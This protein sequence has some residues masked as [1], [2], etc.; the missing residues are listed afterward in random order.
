VVIRFFDSSGLYLTDVTQRKIE[1]LVNREDYRRVLASEIGDI[2]YP[3]R[4]LDH[5]SVALQD[6]IDLDVLQASTPKLVVDYSFGSTSFAMP[7][8]WSKIGA[9]VLGVNPY[10]STWGMVNSDAATRLH[11]VADLVT[12][13]GA[14]LGASIDPD[15]E[16]LTIIDGTGHVLSDTEALLAFVELV[17]GHMDGSSIAV[18]VSVTRHV[19]DTAATGGATVHWTQTSTGALMDAALEPDVGFVG[20]AHGG[21]MLPGFLPAFDAAAALVKLLELLA[22]ADT[23]LAT[24][25]GRLPRPHVVH[26]TIVTPWDR[27]GMVMRSL[28]EQTQD[29]DVELVDGVKVWHGTDWVLALPDVSEPIT[30]LWAEGDD[31][32]A[33]QRLAD[34]YARRITELVR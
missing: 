28:V 3:P 18:P 26:S 23:S 8:L 15:G 14:D 25:V 12:T 7:M 9:D 10:G 17:A 21:F 1:R 19:S 20:D 32:A 30:H 13:S 22:L 6:T 34:E 5:Y 31:E 29:L 24:V 33:A 27:K 4:A 11:R 16:R 2:A